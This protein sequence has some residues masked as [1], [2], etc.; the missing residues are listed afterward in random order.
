MPPTPP[1][2][3]PAS[4]ERLRN[5]AMRLAAELD[6]VRLF[7][8]AAHVSMGAD[9]IS[10]G[11]APELSAEQLRTDVELEFEFDEHGRVW[12]IREGDCHIIGRTE[13]V[14]LEMRKFL[15]NVALGRDR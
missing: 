9:A 2:Y 13:A 6:E 11:P 1:S 3:E 15:A 4:V 12:M 10:R 8:A 7:Q 5:A 14:C